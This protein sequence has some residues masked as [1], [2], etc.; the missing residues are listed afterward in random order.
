MA[1]IRH[2]QRSSAAEDSAPVLNRLLQRYA[3]ADHTA[4][5]SYGGPDSA[6]YSS[7]GDSPMGSPSYRGKDA[8]SAGQ[9]PIAAG[10]GATP[11][12]FER[13]AEPATIDASEVLALARGEENRALIE[14]LQAQQRNAHEAVLREILDRTRMLAADR[15]GSVAWV[16]EAQELLVQADRFDPDAV[17]AVL[18]HPS[19][20]RWMSLALRDLSTPATEPS[21]PLPD[22]LVHL[23]SV[24]AAAAV[25]ACISFTLPLPLRDGFAFLPT[26]GVADL[27]SAKADTANIQRHDGLVTISCGGRAMVQVSESGADTSPLWF[28]TRR[29]QAPFGSGQVS[30]VLDDM[31]PYRQPG[32]P[33]PPS[34]L[35]PSEVVHWQ[36]VIRDAGRVLTRVTPVRAEAL[37]VALKALTPWPGTSDAVVASGSSGDA[38]GGLMASVPP[39]GVELAA[40]LVHE[41]QH[42]K[43][44][45]VLDSLELHCE[46]D[47]AVDEAFYGPWR[48]DPRPVAG[49]FHGVFAFFGVMDFWRKLSSVSEG[50]E[51]RRAQFQLLYW[52]TQ[53]REAYAA[54]CASPQLTDAGRHFAALMGGATVPWTDDAAVP[55][56]VALLAMEAVV[57][58]RT[59]WRLHHL[60]PDPT[61]VSALAEAW[62]S[63]A[64]PPPRQ[65]IDTLLRPD[66]DVVPS[67][68]YTALLCSAAT[69]PDLLGK[70]AS[71]FAAGF[72]Q[73][74]VDPADLARLRGSFD[75]ARRLSADQVTSRPERCG[76]WVRLGLALRRLRAAASGDPADTAE[77]A[78]ALTHRPELVQALYAQV[79]ADTGT[80]PDPVAL[81]AWVGFQDGTSHFPDLPRMDQVFTTGP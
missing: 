13:A 19:V 22:S 9:T 2:V 48:D 30:L 26:L 66:H 74:E 47:D 71:A 14:R 46:R 18:L 79:L 15:S 4:A 51:L 41:F 80:A 59:R 72:G 23:R 52:S 34:P 70:H 40:T 16:R 68:D 58:H 32:G 73:D 25:R 7:R 67:G 77:A 12:L 75:D 3:R 69:A 27:R 20:G 78:G 6:S 5:R 24:A 61:A 43:L 81:A 29:V 35:P 60:R 56:D 21:G 11:G 63:A 65:H 38:F 53:T 33:V 76:A 31:D 17:T 10:S 42:M 37:A 62:S 1:N 64:S 50:E 36:Q 49:L 28:P 45:A 57:A 55:D 8:V 39:D 44:N 54:L